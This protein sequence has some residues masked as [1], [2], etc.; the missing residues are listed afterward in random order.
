MSGPKGNPVGSREAGFSLSQRCKQ[1]LVGTI[2]GDGCLERNGRNVRLR[3]DHAESQ[4][5]FVEWKF[6]ELSELS[7]SK[8][9]LTA[10]LDLRTNQVHRNLRFSTCTTPVLNPFFGFFYEGKPEKFIPDCIGDLMKSP[11]SLAVWYMDDGGRRSDCRSG[12]LNTNAYSVGDVDV[13]KRILFENFKVST[14]T[15]FAAGKPRIYVPQSQFT[16]FCDLI[17]PHVINEMKY[18]LL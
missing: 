12:Y 7:P 4:S 15:H 14:R 10:R 6:R 17:R 9:R 2:L 3:I 5:A 18:K 11:L 1:I 8:P 13:L 16:R